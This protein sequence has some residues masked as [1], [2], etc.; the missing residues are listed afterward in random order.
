MKMIIPLHVVD[1]SFVSCIDLEDIKESLAWV[2]TSPILKNLT[3]HQ[4]ESL[5]S[6]VKGC[7]SGMQ[8]RLND[9]MKEEEEHQNVAE[10]VKEKNFMLEKDLYKSIIT[11]AKQINVQ[12]VYGKNKCDFYICYNKFRSK[13]SAIS[14]FD[15][16]DIGAFIEELDAFSDFLFL[17]SSVSFYGI[18]QLFLILHQ[19]Q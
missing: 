4:K 16:C 13:S 9:I 5:A 18:I 17:I 15:F 1:F 8:I 19:F 10:E 6:F 3:T 7:R 2:S 14:S 12:L 11:Q